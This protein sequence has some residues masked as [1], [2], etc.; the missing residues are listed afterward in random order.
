MRDFQRIQRPFRS[1]NE[2][3]PGSSKRC[4]STGRAVILVPVLV[5][6]AGPLTPNP[7]LQTQLEMEPMVGIGHFSPPL[8]LKYA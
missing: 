4:R 2:Q 3:W 5:P 6:V 7:L 1:V 8:H